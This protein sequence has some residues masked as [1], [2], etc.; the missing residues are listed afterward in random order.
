MLFVLPVHCKTPHSDCKQIRAAPPIFPVPPQE[1]GRLSEP[2]L[3]QFFGT[4]ISDQKMSFNPNSRRRRPIPSVMML[5]A[6]V[7]PPLLLK[8]VF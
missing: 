5:P 2:A 7:S 4:A 6:N 8:L 3:I 1:I